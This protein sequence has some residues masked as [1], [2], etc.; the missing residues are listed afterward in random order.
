M[1][2]SQN[3]EFSGRAAPDAEFDHPPGATIARMLQAGIA[4]AGWST[5]E[6]DNW[7]D[8]GWF[9]HCRRG[10]GTVEVNFAEIG[11][12]SWLLQ[13]VPARSPGAIGRLFGG[14]VSATEDDVLDLAGV[15]HALLG[16]GGFHSL[17]WRWNGMPSEGA[18]TEK[19]QPRPA[20]LA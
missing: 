6:F 1:S 16:D 7:R 11:P 10:E 17:R 4:T 8:C 20:D 14:R 2:F 18:T 9:V 3:V 15:V 13:I 19:P 5:H 12:E